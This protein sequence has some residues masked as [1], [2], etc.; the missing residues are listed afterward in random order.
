M[1]SERERESICSMERHK[2][3]LVHRLCNAQTRS[4][5]IEAPTSAS[6]R[7]ILRGSSSKNSSSLSS[8]DSGKDQTSIGPFMHSCSES[9]DATNLPYR[10]LTHARTHARTHAHMYV[11]TLTDATP[12]SPV[13]QQRVW[14]ARG[15]PQRM[16]TPSQWR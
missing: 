3:V 5:D 16:E 2:G 6:L 1:L 8:A 9:E 15:K 14:Q 12:Y 7:A 10:V 11:H 4:T 13:V